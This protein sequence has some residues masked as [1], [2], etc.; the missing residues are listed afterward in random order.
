MTHHA[1]HAGMM[2][3]C[4][5]ARMLLCCTLKGRGVPSVQHTCCHSFGCAAVYAECP[6][7]GSVNFDY[8]STQA[9]IWEKA[10]KSPSCGDVII[11]GTHKTHSVFSVYA[12]WS[13]AGFVLSAACRMC[14]FFEQP[15]NCDMLCDVPCHRVLGQGLHAEPRVPDPVA[16]QP[17]GIVTILRFS[18]LAAGC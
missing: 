17:G 14:V 13:G 12:V 11:V 3:R 7:E 1:G 6:V 18:M 8:C 9:S 2:R 15:L 16:A 10:A 4:L 5:A